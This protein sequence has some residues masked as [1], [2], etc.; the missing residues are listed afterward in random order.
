MQV[1]ICCLIFSVP[2]AVIFLLMMR[3]IAKRLEQVT[4]TLEANR[5]AMQEQIDLL[6]VRLRFPAHSDT[7]PPLGVPGAWVVR[8]Q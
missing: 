7:E 6:A 1:V 2:S 3:A 8:P 4:A 5:I